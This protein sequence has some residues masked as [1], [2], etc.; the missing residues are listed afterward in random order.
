MTKKLSDAEI[1]KQEALDMH[2]HKFKFNR[3]KFIADIVGFHEACIRNDEKGLFYL[4]KI[5]NIRPSTDNLDKLSDQR[6]IQIHKW[7]WDDI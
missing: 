5:D 2:A 3:E 1:K 4:K 7:F 6:L